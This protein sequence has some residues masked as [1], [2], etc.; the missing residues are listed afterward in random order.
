MRQAVAG[1]WLSVR[2]AAAE[3]VSA[4]LQLTADSFIQDV[5]WNTAAM[6]SNAP[7]LLEPAGEECARL[8][9]ALEREMQDLCG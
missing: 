4:V 7:D 3:R 5:R 1:L 8:R 9:L 2:R 6:S